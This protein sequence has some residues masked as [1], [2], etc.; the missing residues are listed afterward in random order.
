D[1]RFAPGD[2]LEWVTLGLIALV[3]ARVAWS[4]VRALR[5]GA[6]SALIAPAA[7][8]LAQLG[9]IGLAVWRIEL[10]AAALA[11]HYVEY[12]LLMTPRCFDTPLSARAAPDRVLGALRQRPVYLYGALLAL[13][14]AALWLRSLAPSG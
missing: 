8:L 9:S 12:L 14:V 13:A 2:P 7:Y 6:R 10:Y 1:G 4:F 5:A 3:L 11:I